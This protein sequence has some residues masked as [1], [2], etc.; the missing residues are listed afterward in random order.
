[1][2]R[3]NISADLR[4]AITTQE[5]KTVSNNCQHLEAIT[6]WQVAWLSSHQYRGNAQKKIIGK[7][8]LKVVK[9]DGPKATRNLQMC[10]RQQGG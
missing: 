9:H 5:R 4:D 2:G 10:A 7:F 8:I 3:R 1:M 6:G